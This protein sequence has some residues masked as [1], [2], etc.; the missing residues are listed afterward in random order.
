MILFLGKDIMAPVSSLIVMTDTS[1][2][3]CCHLLVSS[4]HVTWI[5]ASDWSLASL[6]SH[7]PVI[8]R[9]CLSGD[10]IMTRRLSPGD[11]ILVIRLAQAKAKTIKR[12][13]K[14]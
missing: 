6:V 12:G 13:P 11:N 2:G 1:G 4:D 10:I 5:L 9:D 8:S 3:G 7:V 14:I